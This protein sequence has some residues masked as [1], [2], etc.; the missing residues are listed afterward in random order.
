MKFC[1]FSA[2]EGFIIVQRV[3]GTRQRSPWRRFAIIPVSAERAEEAG[4][5]EGAMSGRAQSGNEIVRNSHE[6]CQRR[7]RIEKDE[8]FLESHFLISV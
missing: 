7:D 4:G 1:K 3:R 8:L 6:K 5:M 2:P